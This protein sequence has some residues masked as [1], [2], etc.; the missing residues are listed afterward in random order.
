[1]VPTWQ[2]LLSALAVDIRIELRPSR[3]SKLPQ[4]IPRS[5]YRAVVDAEDAI[6]A[7]TNV[8]QSENG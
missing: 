2:G 5:Y 1:V 3:P 6:V 7:I 4:E 8:E